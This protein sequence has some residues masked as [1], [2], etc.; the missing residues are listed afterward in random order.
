MGGMCSIYTADDDLGDYGLLFLNGGREVRVS[1]EDLPWASAHTWSFNG[2]RSPYAIRMVRV[3]GRR[4]KTY[5]HRQICVAPEG[6]VVNHNNGNTLDCRRGNL[7][8][9][10]VRSN[11]TV[12]RVKRG[13]TGLLGVTQ[14]RRGGEVV[15]YRA[16][17]QHAGDNIHLGSFKDKVDA[18][19]A[20][21]RRSVELLGI[22]ADTNFPLEEY[23][24]PGIMDWG[25][26]S[27][28]SADHLEGVPF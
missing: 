1:P 28:P 12:Y 26:P 22:Y 11:S 10:R 25:F 18:A 17:I 23:L 5:L 7:K 13:I 27:A 19:R 8:P 6:M 16:R 3:D 14:E 15:S 21:D 9:V 2:D 20:Y 24:C 4:R